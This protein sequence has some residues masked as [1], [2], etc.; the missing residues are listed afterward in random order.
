MNKGPVR[1]KYLDMTSVYRGAAAIHNTNIQDVLSAHFN[2][3][4]NDPLCLDMGLLI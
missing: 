3:L 4:K 1:I 2:Y